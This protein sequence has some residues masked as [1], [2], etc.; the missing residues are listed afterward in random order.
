M[1]SKICQSNSLLPSLFCSACLHICSP[2]V[3]ID[4][5][6]LCICKVRST[7]TT[8]NSL[9]FLPLTQ[10]IPRDT[11]L[12]LLCLLRWLL[13]LILL[14]LL[15]RCKWFLFLFFVLRHG[16]LCLC[17]LLQFIG[18]QHVG[19]DAISASAHVIGGGAASATL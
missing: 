16:R 12:L 6:L 15:G 14:L 2:I 5:V 4:R 13:L 1:K 9:L 3:F 10:I 8:T 7:I 18:C 19:V 11:H 17:F